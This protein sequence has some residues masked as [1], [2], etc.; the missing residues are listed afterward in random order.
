M[1]RF[2]ATPRRAAPKGHQSSIFRTAP[3]TPQSPTQLRRKRS[4]RTFFQEFVLYAQFSEFPLGL[5]QSGP[6]AHIQRRLVIRVLHPIPIDPV[7]Q[8]PLIDSKFA[9]DLNDRP[10]S[11]DH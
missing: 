10:R 8:G 2:E 1:R 7:T 5:A 4:W 9:G 6:L 3:P 11:L